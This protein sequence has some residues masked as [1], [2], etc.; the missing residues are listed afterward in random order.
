MVHWGSLTEW[1]NFGYEDVN[2]YLKKS[3]KG[4]G[5]ITV[6]LMQVK[7][8]TSK[9]KKMDID[10]IIDDDDD[11]DDDDDRKVFIKKC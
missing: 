2:G 1:S 8:L 6:E 11:D 3:V 4:S 10:E 9:L 7:H 5:D